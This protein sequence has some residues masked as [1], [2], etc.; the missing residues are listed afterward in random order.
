MFKKYSDKIVEI[1][2]SLTDNDIHHIVEGSKGSNHHL[3][4]L[5]S[6][7]DWNEIKNIIIEVMVNGKEEPYLSMYCKKYVIDGKV[8]QV[9]YNK[10]N[11]AYKISDAYVI[12]DNPQINVIFIKSDML[13]CL[14]SVSDSS[15]G[16]I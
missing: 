12:I 5:S 8:V 6:N 2:D 16:F 13:E 15:G 1:V 11:G 10:Y 14:L 7:K 9:N 3:E 4:L